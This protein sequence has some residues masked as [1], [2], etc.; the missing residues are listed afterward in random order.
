[1]LTPHLNNL[2]R[3]L[4]TYVLQAVQYWTVYYPQGQSKLQ[5]QVHMIDKYIWLFRRQYS[6]VVIITGFL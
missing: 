5:Q 2:L 4:W 6:M 3:T 1:M